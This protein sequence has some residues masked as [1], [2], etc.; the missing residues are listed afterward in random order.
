MTAPRASK[1]IAKALSLLARLQESQHLKVE[2]LFYLAAEGDSVPREELLGVLAS[3]GDPAPAA[4]LKA[5]VDAGLIRNRRLQSAGDTLPVLSLVD[6]LRPLLMLPAFYCNRLRSRL[7]SAGLADLKRMA[8]GFYSHSPISADEESRNTVAI[9]AGMKALL[10]NPEA[11]KNAVGE[12]LDMAQRAMLKVLSMAPNGLSLRELKQH[13]GYFGEK[14]GSEDLKQML[15]ETWRI[16]GLI[17]T[18]EGDAVL[19]RDQYFPSDTRVMLV[20][21][22][23][24]MVKGNFSLDSAPLQIIPEFKARQS[25]DT[26]KVRLELGMGFR[27]AMVILTWLISHRVS[28]ILKGGVHKTEIRKVNTMF[29]PPQEDAS[30]FNHLFDYFEQNDIVRVHNGVWAVNVSRAQKFFADPAATLTDMMTDYYGTDLLDRAACDTRADAQDAGSFEPLRVVWLLRYVS[31]QVWIG[32]EEFAHIY[33]Q[34]DGGPR[35]TSYRK[36]VEKFIS[37]QLERPLFW[38]GLVELSRDPDEGRLLFRLSE[39]GR[40]VLHE[41]RLP[42]DLEQMFV[43][44]EKLLVQSNLE[45]FLPN[46]FSPAGTL[47]LARFADYTGKCFKISNQSLS[48]GLD[49]GLKLEQIREFLRENSSQEIPQNVS[50]LLEEVANRHGHLLVDPQRMLIKTETPFL[51]KELSI[52]PGLRRYYLAQIS[53]TVM[54]LAHDVRVPRMVEELRR[55]GYLPRVRWDAVIDEGV[56]QLDLTLEERQELV[57]LLKA[58][59]FSD[60]VDVRLGQT[61]RQIDQQL[62]EEDQALKQATKQRSLGHSYELLERL[63]RAVRQGYLK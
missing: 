62:D 11:F 63:G 31:S 9:L 37:H 44:E 29:T 7:A 57:A 1:E 52:V 22:A 15:Q 46:R 2:V 18:S 3:A 41:G 40:C 53:D 28:R 24:A 13:L 26:W 50:Y 39:R 51:L 36:E 47:F 55:M 59:E 30:L 25:P 45:I 20:Q 19:R 43:R 42:E 10:L 21:D 61:L 56:D 58:Y 49:S 27:N 17:Y 38:F 35:D 5:L 16:C 54:L 34:I 12:H 48:R 60:Q 14:L 23:V 6:H 33:T 32:V 4:S 8:E